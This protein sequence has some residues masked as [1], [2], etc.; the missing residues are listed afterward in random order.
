M[1]QLQEAGVNISLNF[2]DT[3]PS[4]G[5]LSKSPY[6]KRSGFPTGNPNF[7][8]VHHYYLALDCEN[9]DSH[10]NTRFMSETGFQ[11]EASYID[12]K[13]V[14]HPMELGQATRYMEER[15]TFNQGH[16]IMVNQSRRHFTLPKDILD[17]E[18][19]SYYTW[20]SQI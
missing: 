11:S 20:L 4:N 13:G 2:M 6:T 7:G 9:P 19:F 14:A 5:L 18:H 3:S 1:P 16:D 15:T 10:P 12:Y 8:D 17:Q